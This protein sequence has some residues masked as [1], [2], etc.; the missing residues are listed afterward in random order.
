MGSAILAL[1][2]LAGIRR[3]DEQAMV[4]KAVSRG[5]FLEYWAGKAIE[6]SELNEL[7]STG[8]WR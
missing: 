8:T 2:V 6:C 5:I 7:Y 1:V 4:S 3:H